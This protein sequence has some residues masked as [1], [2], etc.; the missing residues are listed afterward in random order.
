MTDKQSRQRSCQTAI[1]PLNQVC[2]VDTTDE[3][4]NACE[5]MICPSC[6]NT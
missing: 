3:E 5:F 4:E 1:N 6:K 2:P